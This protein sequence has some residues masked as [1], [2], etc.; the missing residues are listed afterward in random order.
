MLASYHAGF[1]QGI[2]HTIGATKP[3]R[4]AKSGAMPQRADADRRKP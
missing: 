2:P 3:M 4:D 1:K